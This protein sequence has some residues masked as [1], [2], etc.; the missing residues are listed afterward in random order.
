MQRSRTDQGADPGV[1]ALRTEQVRSTYAHLP[2]T[3][4]VVI[5]N[6][7]LISFVLAPVA[8]P[9]L[10]LGWLGSVALLSALRVV[11]WVLHRRLDRSAISHPAW[12][13]LA[14]TGSLLSGI[15]WGGMPLL[16][17]ALDSTYLV[18]FALVIG[19]MCA[20]AATVHAAHLPSTLCYVL[21]ASLPAAVMFLMRDS[22]LDIAVGV[23]I[24]IFAVSLCLAG[25]NY[26]RWFNAST[27]A[28][29]TLARQTA[30]L[31][32]MNERLR[33]EIESHH[34]TA[35]KLQQSQRLEAMGRLTAGLA[36]D[37]N[38]LLMAIRGSA[39]VA[40]HQTPPGAPAPRF[41]ATIMTAV[42][43]AATLT[44]RLLAFGRVQTLDPQAIDVNEALQA[45]QGLLT[46]TLGG[47]AELALVLDRSPAVAVVDPP[48][49]EQAVLN[50]VIN[51]RD[52]MPDGGRI[53]I[54][55][56]ICELAEEGRAGKFVCVAV[57]DTGHGMTETE[58][59]H[60]FD[61]FFTTKEIG[62]GSGLGLSQ[63]YGLAEQSGGT[64]RIESEV[65]EG[66]TV[67][68][69]LPAAP[70]AAS[71]LSAAPRSR[72]VATSAETHV[73][74]LD[75]DKEVRDT[76]AALLAAAGYRVT[77]HASAAAALSA[78]QG[79]DRFALMLVDYAMP[80]MRGDQFAAE[81]RRLHALA[82]IVFITGHVDTDILA[83]EP[84]ILRKP[85]GVGDLTDII[86]K[87]LLQHA[88]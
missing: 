15:Q 64:A 47:L 3:L 75:D 41:L 82:P 8:R 37:F 38:N 2:L 77:A 85:F 42:G 16:F 63:V 81:A 9:A 28:R 11:L 21:P 70:A 79:P 35:A 58:R 48:Q 40:A 31:A 78:L 66:T 68:I 7:S 24:G 26:R 43:R 12:A 29:M 46:T 74:L 10:V 25:L 87:A 51:A 14:T 23:M 72:T 36:H 44:Q 34:A 33:A 49:F 54:S 27:S 65:G 1:D 84:W 76:L 61:P 4:T 71:S 45:M 52:A 20:G 19:G 22:R 13:V 57:S 80:A 6:A 17:W 32:E 56:R 18:F 55:T 50:L 73:L 5:T 59:E 67:S 86:E 39:E 69:Y 30:E 62:K 53:T 88:A 60:A 83:G